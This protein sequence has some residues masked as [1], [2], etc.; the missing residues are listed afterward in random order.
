MRLSILAAVADSGVIGR[1]N[2]LPWHLPAD[3][4]RF[5]QL[6]MGHPIIMGR[7]TWESIGR[8]LPGRRTLVLSRDPEFRL[9]DVEVYSRLA[10]A[11]AAVADAQ[12]AF[13][14]GGAALFDEALA[15]ADRLYLTRVHAG[16]DGDT[17]F[18][19]VDLTQ[20]RLVESEPRAADDANRLPVTFETWDRIEA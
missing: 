8:P 20:W 12:E 16:I 11:L 18:P 15:L 4:R 5:R 9:D 10:V 7:L 6:T 3:L 2:E 19:P 14:V 13:V 1:D 17:W